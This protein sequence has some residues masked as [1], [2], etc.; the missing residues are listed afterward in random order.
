MIEFGLFVAGIAI[1]SF[2]TA[3]VVGNRARRLIH[4]RGEALRTI[5]NHKW[6]VGEQNDA[7]VITRIAMT[8]LEH[9]QKGMRK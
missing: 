9:K 3:K 2:V 1:G 6:N 5:T 8:G 4:I 7:A